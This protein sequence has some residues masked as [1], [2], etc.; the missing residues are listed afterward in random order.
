[1]KIC[2]IN[3]NFQMGG[4]QKV[5]TDI[6]NYFSLTQ[7][8]SVISLTKGEFFYELNDQI[9]K[10]IFRK[11]NK[12]KIYRKIIKEYSIKKRG[13][14]NILEYYKEELGKIIDYIKKGE[15]D[16]VILSQGALTTFTPI[17][18]EAVPRV[19]IISWQHSEASMYLQ[20]YNKFF[21]NE[22]IDGLKKSDRVICLTKKDREIFKNYNKKSVQIYN[23][24]EI[25]SSKVTSLHNRVI[26]YAGRILIKEK[27]IKSILEAMSYIDKD[28][29]LNIAG[30]GTKKEFKKLKELVK[31][32]NLEQR[33][34]IFGK[35]PSNRMA[36]FYN[37]ADI[38][39]SA[40]EWEGFGLT[41]VEAMKCGLPIVSYNNSGPNEILDYGEYGIIIVERNPRTL[42]ERINTIINNDELMNHLQVKSIE[43][44]K[45]FSLN[46]ISQDWNN[47]INNL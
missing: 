40:S 14:F 20:N 24:S 18:K 8:V 41:I 35:V 12:K 43:R 32:Y 25:E 9:E 22:Y 2:F 47:L 33:I 27:G 44:S 28:I 3:S 5:I 45:D 16:I 15:I 31:V 39:V 4:V 21:L 11:K 26:C 10:V 23:V 19:K 17:I 38:Y 1:M 36:E 34:N 37:Q 42:G 29:S 6:A 13:Y 46:R 30:V 7:E